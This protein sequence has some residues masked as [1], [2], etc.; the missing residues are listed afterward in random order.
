MASEDT[1]SNFQSS[2]YT[3]DYLNDREV[4]S[5][6]DEIPQCI[7]EENEEEFLQECEN[8]KRRFFE[9]GGAEKFLSYDRDDLWAHIMYLYTEDFEEEDLENVL[10]LKWYRSKIEFFLSQ[11]IPL[12][13]EKSV[14]SDM[15]ELEPIYRPLIKYYIEELQIDPNIGG[16]FDSTQNAFSTVVMKKNFWNQSD[17]DDE[18]LYLISHGA[19]P[20]VSESFFNE[21]PLQYAAHIHQ[22]IDLYSFPLVKEP[23]D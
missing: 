3:R 17:I 20:D 16:Y 1:H 6:L 15:Y 8:F 7:F 13:I 12:N 18:L 14:I 21:L 5:W 11:G 2:L 23:A 9:I 19:T 22:L 10:I 4:F